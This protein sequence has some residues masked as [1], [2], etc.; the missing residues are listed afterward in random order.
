MFKNYF[1]VAI[2][3]LK[4]YKLISFINLFG[5][6]VGLSCCMLILTYILHEL[7]FDKYNRNADRIYRVTRSFNTLDGI[8]T[9]RLGTVAP[10]FGPLLAHDF[11]EIQA[12]TELLPNGTTALRYKEKNFNEKNLFY[13]DENLFKVFDVKLIRGNPQTALRDPFSIM[14]SEAEADKY[15]GSADPLNKMIMMENRF[16]LKVTGVYASF[17]SNAHIHPELMLSFRTLGDTA[18]YGA[19]NLR[20][21][22]GNNSFLTYL[23]MPAHY[24][25]EKMLTSFPSF[26]DAHLNPKDY[27]GLNP[28]KTDKLGLQKLTDI[29]L[30]SHMDSEAEENGD[31]KRV[32]IFS[33]IALFILLIACINYMNLS[34]ARS[35]LRSREI[36]IRKVVGAQKRELIF[37]FLCESILISWAAILLAIGLLFLILPGLNKLSGQ[38][39]SIKSLLNWQ[40]LMA[41]FFIPFTVGIISGI[42]PALFMSSFQPVKT[43][44]G[45]FKTGGGSISLRKAL[46]VTQFA[47]SIILI[48]ST[49]VVFEQLRYMQESKLGYNKEHILVMAN[50]AALNPGYESFRNALLQDAHIKNASRSSRIPTGRLLDGEIAASESGDSLQQVKAD[51]RYVAVDQDF[52][53]SFGIDIAAGRNFSRDFV[54]DSTAFVLNETAVRAIGWRSNQ[55]A[56][57][58]HFSYG[59]VKG[60]VI[61]V[62]KDFHFESM[63]QQIAPIAFI[64]PA[65]APNLYAH[66][67]IKMA[68]A[69]VMQALTHIEKTW[70]QYLP[71]TPFEYTFLDENFGRLYAS[72]QK[73]ETLFTIFACIAVF[74]AALGL[75]GLSAFAITQR[76]RELGIRKVLGAS[77]GSIVGLLSKDFLLLVLIAALIAFPL[78]GYAMHNWL[79]DFAYHIQMPWW[80]FLMAALAAL[81]I[82]LVTVSAL[83]IK[84]ASANPVKSLRTE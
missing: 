37:Q 10:P 36:G 20:T 50:N 32:Y 81:S 75:F 21:D 42:Y 5:L 51:I 27:G 29:H 62:L 84:A 13:A 22:F 15:F 70:R 44:K 73:Q 34:T 12:V 82:T 17:P 39:L 67:S 72:E 1:I 74:I 3:N 2:R 77:I 55:E 61:G 83:A 16:N 19:E 9:L 56:I 14:L 58:K 68:G 38:D 52:V 47:I 78:A 65:N 66:I 33:A 6:T 35:A 18:I 43:L 69:G 64:M 23:L 63:H 11:P 24:P 54:S 30:R 79:A 31:I 8:T 40:I 7:S 49:A 4:K 48:I 41:V 26:L 46:V 60:K 25:L 71:Q 59:G 28:S 45:L 76:I 53:P 80:V 57:G